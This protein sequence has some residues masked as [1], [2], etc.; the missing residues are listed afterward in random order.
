MTN[1]IPAESK[2]ED[3]PEIFGKAQSMIITSRPVI[4]STG[5]PFRDRYCISCW[6]KIKGS[7]AVVAA[8]CY[9]GVNLPPGTYPTAISVVFHR[10]CTR[11]DPNVLALDLL[12][13][14]QDEEEEEFTRK[15]DRM[16]TE[17]RLDSFHLPVSNGVWHLEKVGDK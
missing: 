8:A 14:W 12:H 5:H 9:T 4:F 13:A 1:P 6:R 3:T 11:P 7:P 10:D 16:L 2:T 15:L 17:S